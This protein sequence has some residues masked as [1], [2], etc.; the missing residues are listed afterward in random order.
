MQQTAFHPP[1]CR[2]QCGRSCRAL[3]PLATHQ[4]ILKSVSS[5]HLFVL[6]LLIFTQGTDLSGHDDC[7]ILR[8]W[9]AEPVS[10]LSSHLARGQHRVLHR[11]DAWSTFAVGLSCFI[12]LS[13][14]RALP[15]HLEDV[16]SGPRV[17]YQ[18]H[19]SLRLEESWGHR[20]HFSA[21][22]AEAPEGT[23]KSTGCLC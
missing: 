8:F 7:F 18:N 21:K 2:R 12:R 15:D 17:H 13:L 14:V 22:Q 16:A 19:R 5:Q 20:P 23:R 3:G 10:P 11:S 6:N 4:T 9:L 1:S